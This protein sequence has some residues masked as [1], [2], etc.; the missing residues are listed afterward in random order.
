L[1]IFQLLFLFF[2]DNTISP[3]KKMRKSRNA[4]ESKLSGKLQQNNDAAYLKT[5]STIQLNE[6]ENIREG[7]SLTKTNGFHSNNG[8]KTNESTL[9]LSRS[10]EN[11]R[12]V[13]GGRISADCVDTKTDDQ[14]A[15]N[16][17]NSGSSS[18][19]DSDNSSNVDVKESRNNE[20]LKKRDLKK[21]FKK[22][23]NNKPNGVSKTLKSEKF[24]NRRASERQGSKSSRTPEP[25][26]KKFKRRT[27]TASIISET[28]NDMGVRR[29]TT[30]NTQ[31]NS[32]LSNIDEQTYCICDQI[33]FGQM[34]GCD[35]S[36]CK[37]EWFHFDCKFL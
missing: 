36:N 27:A 29:R 21:P 8:E 28:V 23:I 33:S 2:L 19:F 37:I 9:F 32:E 4:E 13:N 25:E 5:G 31:L 10:A 26:S 22:P 34:I 11:E 16:A 1:D 12:S 30:R 20:K 24:G 14:S 15:N 35:N 3:A 17:K 6:D 7:T 18:K